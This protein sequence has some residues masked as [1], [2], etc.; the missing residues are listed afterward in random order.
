MGGRN[1][2]KAG[3]RIRRASDLDKQDKILVY[4]VNRING[5]EREIQSTT[6]CVRKTLLGGRHFSPNSGPSSGLKEILYEENYAVK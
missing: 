6:K 3:S 1:R 5:G 2:A 4:L